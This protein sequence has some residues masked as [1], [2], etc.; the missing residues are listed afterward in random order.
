MEI[1]TEINK[2][3]GTE[4]AKLF[5]DQISEEEM[6][7][8]ARNAWAS[9]NRKEGPAWDQKSK[10]EEIVQKEVA[11][12]L[13]AQVVALLD[14][15]PVKADIRTEA[16]KIVK[17]IRERTAEKFVEQAS[18]MLAGIATGY[19]GASLRYQIECIV[20]EMMRR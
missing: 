5:A 15:E 17:N 1:S 2:I 20:N 6:Q 13:H 3:F 18:D 19:G 8:Y 4:M 12:R 9:L 14:S 10:I 16:E 7:K 11:I